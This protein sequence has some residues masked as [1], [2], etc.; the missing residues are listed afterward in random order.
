[1]PANLLLLS[2]Q[3]SLQ[4]LA[5]IDLVLWFFNL[6]WL[7][8]AQRNIIIYLFSSSIPL[9]NLILFDVFQSD[10]EGGGTAQLGQ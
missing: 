2:C 9:G 7:L 4:K 5:Y 6:C 1:M 10:N 3:D 8:S